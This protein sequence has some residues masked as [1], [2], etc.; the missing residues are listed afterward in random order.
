[1]PLYRG[2]ALLGVMVTCLKCGAKRSSTYRFEAL[3]PVWDVYGTY[4]LQVRKG[5]WEAE[6]RGKGWQPAPIPKKVRQTL[7]EASDVERRRK[8]DL[9]L[10]TALGSIRRSLYKRYPEKE[11]AAQRAAAMLSLTHLDEMLDGE[12]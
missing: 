5:L 12:G 6:G 1:M 9:D 10:Q 7:D 4:P 2:Y 8:L 11:G 3:R